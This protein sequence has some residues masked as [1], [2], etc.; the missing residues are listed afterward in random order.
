MIPQNASKNNTFLPKIYRVDS[1]TDIEIPES[2]LET[3]T[4]EQAL[5]EVLSDFENCS[6]LRIAQTH[7]MEESLNG[8]EKL[9]LAYVGGHKQGYFRTTK[10]TLANLGISRTSFWRAYKNLLSKKL[11][12]TKEYKIYVPEKYKKNQV[13]QLLNHTLADRTLTATD[14]LFCGVYINWALGRIRNDFEIERWEEVQNKCL[15]CGLIGMHRNTLN[16][17]RQRIIQYCKKNKCNEL[18]NKYSA[19]KILNKIAK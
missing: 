10:Q 13:L 14:K 5:E 7:I 4:C 17:S 19:F 1:A 6:V 15:F 16:P 3:K 11:L 12:R 8:T 9:I 18:I 2:L